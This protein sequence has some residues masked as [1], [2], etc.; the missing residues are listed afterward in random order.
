MTV[1]DRINTALDRVEQIGAKAK[2]LFLTAADLSEVKGK[3]DFRGVPIAEGE[4]GGHSYVETEDAPS[5]DIDF[6]I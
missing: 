4:I 2:R 5:G 1:D 3:K 6:T